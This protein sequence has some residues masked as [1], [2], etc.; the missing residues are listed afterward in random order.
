MAD[1]SNRFSVEGFDRQRQFSALHASMPENFDTY[2]DINQVNNIP[3]YASIM[4]VIVTSPGFFYPKESTLIFPDPEHPQGSRAKALPI[5]SV[6]KETFSIDTPGTGYYIGYPFSIYHNDIDYGMSYVSA[7]GANGSIQEL[8]ILYCADIYSLGKYSTTLP[9]LVNQSDNFSAS[10]STNNIFRVASV[11]LFD[12]GSGYLTYNTDFSTPVEHN[13]FL[14][15]LDV[16]YDANFLDINDSYLSY[17]NDTYYDP[18]VAPQNFAAVSSKQP[19]L[20]A[21]ET[22]THRDIAYQ[23]ASEKTIQG[24]T[25]YFYAKNNTL[26]S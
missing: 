25:L 7:T 21:F 9:N 19:I 13:P 16:D 6:Q 17:Y 1:T 24:S 11:A 12:R 10:I 22:Y 2:F 8:D 15:P 20:E 5:F 23:T 26:I 14:Y 3:S 18:S 4:D